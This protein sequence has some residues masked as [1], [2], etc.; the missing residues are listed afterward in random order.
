V[1]PGGQGTIDEAGAAKVIDEPEVTIAA[2]D[3][4]G[5]ILLVETRADTGR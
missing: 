5:E 1:A 4:G 2:G 3:Q